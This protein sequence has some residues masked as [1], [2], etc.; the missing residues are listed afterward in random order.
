M[1]GLRAFLRQSFVMEFASGFRI[2]CGVGGMFVQD[3]WFLFF[4]TLVA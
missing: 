3:I 1:R 4:Y 2:G